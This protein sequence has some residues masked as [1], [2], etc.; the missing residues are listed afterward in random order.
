[1][2]NN[3]HQPVMREIAPVTF[4]YHRARVTMPEL[5]SLIP[6]SGEL[7]KEAVQQGLMITGPIHWHYDGFDGN[8]SNPFTLDVCLP[9]A[10]A[11]ANFSGRFSIKRTP[12]YRCV[13][14]QHQGSWEEIGKSY[15]AILGYLNANSIKPTQASREL[16]INADLHNPAANITEIQWSID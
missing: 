14:I 3:I 13:S 15:D 5:G 10:E 8:P 16:Y 7:F 12:V 6:I 11:P 9:V 4:L 1:M 2:K